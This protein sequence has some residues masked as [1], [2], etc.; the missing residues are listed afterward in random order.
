M[1]DR[2]GLTRDRDKW[3]AVVNA[4]MNLRGPPNG[5]NQLSSRVVLISLK[6]V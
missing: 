4:A 5:G 6:V 1:I 2:T 3:R